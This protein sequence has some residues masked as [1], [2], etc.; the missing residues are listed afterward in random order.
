MR[1][2]A[3][4]PARSATASAASFVEGAIK[5]AWPK[6]SSRAGAESAADDDVAGHDR[7]MHEA[8][9]VG[10]HDQGDERGES[11]NRLRRV[12]AGRT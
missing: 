10:A 8:A 11:G 1:V 12:R 2:S 9:R 7:T 5:M 4:N 3:A 6:S